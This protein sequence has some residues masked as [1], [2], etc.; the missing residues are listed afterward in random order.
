MELKLGEIA[1]FT[2]AFREIQGNTW[3]LVF[4]QVHSQKSKNLCRL[5]QL[6]DRLSQA[7]SPVLTD[8]DGD[9]Y[10]GKE[11]L[12]MT[13]NSLTKS[14]LTDEEVEFICDRVSGITTTSLEILAEMSNWSLAVS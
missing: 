8:F 7:N 5:C 12:Q 4:I 14:E 3:F 1:F 9:N 11:D 2:F 10:I 13:V 6:E